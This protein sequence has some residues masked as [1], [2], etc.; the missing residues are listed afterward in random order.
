LDHSLRVGVCLI[1]VR[2][3][4]SATLRRPFV[5]RSL[6]QIS[7]AWPKQDLRAAG[8]DRVQVVW[9]YCRPMGT[10]TRSKCRRVRSRRALVILR[11]SE[12]LCRPVLAVEFLCKRGF[13][14]KAGGPQKSLA[15]V[16]TTTSDG[17][18]PRDA[19]YEFRRGTSHVGR[20]T[21]LAW[22]QKKSLF[23]APKK[24]KKSGR[25]VSL[26]AERDTRSRAV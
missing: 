16:T 5:W 25:A 8:L 26:P 21:F 7:R 15:G 2:V 11:H 17:T 9:P 13:L 6:S 24:P 4:R 19:T 12:F 23:S 1:R 18:M 3:F 10:R 14:C 20:G 22:T